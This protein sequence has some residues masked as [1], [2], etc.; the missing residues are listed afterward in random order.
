MR[1]LF[2]ISIILVSSVLYAQT[3]QN[4]NSSNNTFKDKGE[5]I[6]FLTVSEKNSTSN[7]KGDANEK[8]SLALVALY[9]ATDGDNWI[10][11]SNWLTGKVSD[12][13][14]ITLRS[15]G[16]VRKIDLYNNQLTGF[17]PSEIGDITR[18]EWLTLRKNQLTGNIPSEIGNLTKLNY[19][20]LDENQITGSIPSEIGNL[21]DLYQLKLNNNLLSG[22]VPAKIGNLT[23]LVYLFLN[24]N[25]LTG[26][27]PNEFGNLINLV[28]LYLENN[29][30]SGSIPTG[31]SNF[32]K[33]DYFY[34]FNNQ[35]EDLPDISGLTQISFIYL[36]KN[37]FT[38]EDLEKS[39]NVIGNMWNYTPQ[40]NIGEV[41]HYTP[42]PGESL[43]LSVAV[44][45][46]GNTYQW[47][48][49]NIEISGAT[50]NVYS[51]INYNITD[52]SGIYVCKIRNSVANQLTLESRQIYVGVDIAS[53]D[54][55]SEANPIHAGLINGTGTYNDGDTATLVATSN[56]GYDFKYWTENGNIISVDPVLKFNVDKDSNIVANF[57]STFYIST[58]PNTFDGGKTAGTGLYE[59]NDNAHLEA[60]AL[61]GYHFV[62]WTEQ[63]T[64][65]SIDS[66]YIFA[67]TSDRN[68]IANFELD[69]FEI[70][71][72]IYPTN[73]GSVNG[74]G[75][76]D[77]GETVII[78]AS[79][80]T[81][82]HFIN[83]AE[84]GNEITTDTSYTFIVTENRNINAHF[85]IDTFD[86][87]ANINPDNGG[88][89]N[90]SGIYEYGDTAKLIASPA[91]GY[92]FVSWIEEDTMVTNDTIYKFVV[93]ENRTFFANFELDTFEIS[94]NVNPINSGTII[95][96]GIYEY[97]SSVE[98]IA[99]SETGYYFVN[100]TENS[101]ETT[102][103]S[104]YIFTVT[105]NRTL[106]ANFDNTYNISVSIN[107]AE[108]G[109]VTGNG[110]YTYGD[111][112]TIT[113]TSGTG[114]H[115]VNWTEND[116]EVSTNSS[117]D[118]TVTKERN[119]IA[120][121]ELD[122]FE[123]TTTIDP[124]NSG[125]ITRSG[126]YN[127]SDTA[128]LI[129]YPATGYHI[130]KWIEEDTTVSSDTAYSFVVTKNRD[131]T[132][133]FELDTFEISVSANP[134][135]YGS[136]DGAGIYSYGSTAELTATAGPGYQFINWTED[137][138][139]ISIDTV[140][141]FTV[142]TYRNLL[143]NFERV[144]SV[145]DLINSNPVT[146]FPNPV[147]SVLQIQFN[148]F[149]KDNIQDVQI[150]L[151]DYLGRKTDTKSVEI[152]NGDNIQINV[153]DKPEGI[154][155]LQI[156]DEKN[157]FTKT[158][159]LIIKR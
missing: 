90:G 20:F 138:N 51:I 109:T 92:H 132:V 25:Q 133:I 52:D 14:G 60:S 134:S 159:K 7:Y 41:N 117:Y 81:G 86:I 120:N 35:F 37:K 1:K 122:T 26:S 99:K 64:E 16:R 73:S 100:W 154:Y 63:G 43:F 82:Y 13:Y 33:L 55:S 83:W 153:S 108:G 106:T 91:T 10:D 39:M 87:S 144:T 36:Q 27:L 97:G 62:N 11:N 34:L 46:T 17:I 6:N 94:V 69:T 75:I 98:L 128:K 28:L 93:N 5:N 22:S 57:D 157:K 66:S 47:Y 137:G 114:Y 139:E 77:Y 9:Y 136:I 3:R 85:G 42:N 119:L 131:F 4:Q 29:K 96:T 142:E 95:G 31:V 149:D 148:N 118:F 124:D 56:A 107:P 115:F 135:N 155:F 130:V 71:I 158:V 80:D 145:P 30:L 65:V 12:W 156:V 70:A 72:N 129:A 126:I 121:F 21:V 105:E 89:V 152:I 8:D 32:T 143:A 58:N 48:R 19:L 45:G 53:Y 111:L 103:D 123:I 140:Y 76:Y 104:S 116:D 151:F 44:G 147:N 101:D 59:Y 125:T 2:T 49:N 110:I 68:L 88:S 61:T 24:D 84:D 54:I 15:D 102:I 150:N 50:S 67:V 40:D 38:F 127:Y 78:T 113:A 74:Q 112:A 146:V 23:K 79:P 18:L 141:S